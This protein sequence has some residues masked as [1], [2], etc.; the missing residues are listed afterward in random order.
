MVKTH[1]S[2]NYSPWHRSKLN[3]LFVVVTVCSL[4][5]KFLNTHVITITLRRLQNQLKHMKSISFILVHIKCIHLY[6]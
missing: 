6:K 1:I 4:K 2:N 3:K 5:I